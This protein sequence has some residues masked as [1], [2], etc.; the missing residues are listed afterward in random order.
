MWVEGTRS[1]CSGRTFESD[2]FQT[3]VTYLHLANIPDQRTRRTIA[4][5]AARGDKTT[6]RRLAKLLWTFVVIIV[7]RKHSKTVH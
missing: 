3:I 1:P 2:T 5:P 4:F 6:M 7:S